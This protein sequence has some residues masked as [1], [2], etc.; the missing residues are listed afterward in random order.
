MNEIK[1]GL[2]VTPSIAMWLALWKTEKRG[3]IS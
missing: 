3:G 1:M 2:N